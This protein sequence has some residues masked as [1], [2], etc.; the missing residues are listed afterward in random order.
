MI[1]SIIFNFL[2]YIRI[3]SLAHWSYLI[4]VTLYPSN[5]PKLSLAVFALLMCS[6]FI[7]G[8]IFPRLKLL[9]TLLTIPPQVHE[10]LILNRS[11]ATTVDNEKVTTFIRFYTVMSIVSTLWT[12]FF[13]CKRI[14]DEYKRNGRN[15]DRRPRPVQ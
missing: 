7:P 5:G 3:G 11:I 9:V 12:I 15:R 4:G 14:M 2:W 6:S 8:D 10:L 13:V 1:T